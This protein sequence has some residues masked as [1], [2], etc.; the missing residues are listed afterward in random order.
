MR[1][2]K[3]W[4]CPVCKSGSWSRTQAVYVRNKKGFIRIGWLFSC[5]HVDIEHGKLL[6]AKGG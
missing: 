5:G 1:I 6:K 3:P 4:S 2:S